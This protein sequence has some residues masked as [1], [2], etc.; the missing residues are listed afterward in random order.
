MQLRQTVMGVVMLLS[1]SDN[2][3]TDT[4]MVEDRLEAE[5]AAG[6]EGQECYTKPHAVMTAQQT[7][8]QE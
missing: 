2:M 7:D 5:V 4:A 3:R 1:G 8:V 6:R